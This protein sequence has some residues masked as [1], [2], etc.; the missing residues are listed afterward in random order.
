MRDVQRIDV[1]LDKLSKIWKT[2]PDLR[3]GQLLLNVVKDP[4]LYYVE[5]TPLM[6]QLSNFYDIIVSEPE[7][8][9]SVSR[10]RPMDVIE[11]TRSY[12]GGF[13][14]VTRCPICKT[15]LDANKLDNYCSHCGQKLNWP[16]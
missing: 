2:V 10:D 8:D 13:F 3:L 14:Y 15:Y 9:V 16:E 11:I 4:E 6:L 7:S 5:D 12:Y 1:V